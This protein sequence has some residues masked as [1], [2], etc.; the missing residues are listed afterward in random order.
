MYRSIPNEKLKDD[1]LRFLSSMNRDHSILY[2]VELVCFSTT[3]NNINIKDN[4]IEEQEENLV[5]LGSIIK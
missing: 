2:D 1:V 5:Q 4:E 3:I